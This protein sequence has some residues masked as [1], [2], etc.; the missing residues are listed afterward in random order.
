MRVSDAENQRLIREA[1][2]REG[3]RF[4]RAG[5]RGI[6]LSDSFKRTIVTALAHENTPAAIGTLRELERQGWTLPAWIRADL[7]RYGKV[8]GWRETE[9]EALAREERQAAML[10]AGPILAEHRRSKGE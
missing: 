10:D 3:T 2:E 7:D 9:R 1:A 8:A 4:V 5:D 6:S